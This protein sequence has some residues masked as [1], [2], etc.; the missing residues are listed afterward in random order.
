MRRCATGESP[1]AAASCGLRRDARRAS[2]CTA[3]SSVLAGVEVQR[4]AELV[5]LRRAG[6][7]D[8]GRLLARVVAAEAALAERAEQIAQRA[9]AEEVERLVG[10]LE[11]DRRLIRARAAAA[12]L[13]PLALGLEIRRHRDVALARAI[14]S[15]ICWISSSSFDRASS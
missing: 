3:L 14:R 2:R 10:D 1:D 15:M 6:R 13:P 4:V 8:A 7:L 9:V 5:R 12:P 11:R